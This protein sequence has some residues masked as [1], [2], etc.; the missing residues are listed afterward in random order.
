M[1]LPHPDHRSLCLYPQMNLLNLH[2]KK[3]PSLCPP[4]TRKNPVYAT[5]LRCSTHF[6]LFCRVILSSLSTSKI[7]L[8]LCNLEFPQNLHGGYYLCSLVFFASLAI[9]VIGAGLNSILD[10]WYPWPSYLM[11]KVFLHNCWPMM[12]YLT[13][14]TTHSGLSITVCRTAVPR[15]CLTLGF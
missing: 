9:E 10:F 12:I 6:T 8:I 4:P 15:K 7:F 14:W 2:R 13:T 11:Q 3:I 1:G 5:V